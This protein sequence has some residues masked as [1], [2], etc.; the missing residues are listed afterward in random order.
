MRSTLFLAALAYALLVLLGAAGEHCGLDR[1][2]KAKH[3]QAPDPL[4]LQARVSL[5]RRDPCDEQSRRNLGARAQARVGP[6]SVLDAEV[7]Q[8]LLLA[9]R[10]LLR[11]LESAST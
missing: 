7:A 11:L 3:D 5:V 9:G 2:L 1:T 4:A 10:R 8:R 6:S